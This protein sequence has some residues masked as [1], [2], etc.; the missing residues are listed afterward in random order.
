MRSIQRVTAAARFLGDRRGG[1]AD[2]APGVGMGCF[3]R[4]Q[5]VESGEVSASASGADRPKGMAEVAP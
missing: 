1:D 3:A 5:T 4:N 2:R